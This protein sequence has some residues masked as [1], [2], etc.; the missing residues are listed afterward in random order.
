MTTTVAVWGRAVLLAFG[1]CLALAATPAEAS[2]SW[3]Q[4]GLLYGGNAGAPSTGPWLIG[5]CPT[6]H[7]DYEPPRSRNT[8]LAIAAIGGLGAFLCLGYSAISLRGDQWT[9]RR[10]R[11]G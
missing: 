1:I 5:D 8:E 6:S 7:P 2:R 4:D 9:P 11:P 3:C 10:G